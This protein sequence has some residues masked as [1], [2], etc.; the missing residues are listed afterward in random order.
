MFHFAYP[1]CGW[2][3]GRWRQG[4]VKSLSMKILIIYGLSMLSLGLMAETTPYKGKILKV[5][6]C[7]VQQ[8][9]DKAERLLSAIAKGDTQP[10]YPVFE[11]ASCYLSID[12]ASVSYSP[13]L[14]YRTLRKVESLGQRIEDAELFL[15]NYGL[16]MEELRNAIEVRLFTDAQTENSIAG[17]DRFLLNIDNES[18]KQ[19]A[20]ERRMLLA[21]QSI[22]Q[23]P[24]A[25]RCQAFID[26]YPQGRYTAEITLLRDRLI[27][28]S[29]GDN[30]RQLELFIQEHPSSPYA[31]EARAK[32]DQI[33]APELTI[34]Q[35]RSLAASFFHG[36]QV[37][38]VFP[39][40]DR[41]NG[42]EQFIAVVDDQILGGLTVAQCS[43]EQVLFS[44][45]LP[46]T[47]NT[48]LD[49]RRVDR[50]EK[51]VIN[52]RL[53]ILVVYRYYTY[54]HDCADCVERGYAV[55]DPV[56]HRVDQVVI[57][58]FDLFRADGTLDRIEG[59]WLPCESNERTVWL[60][61]YAHQELGEAFQE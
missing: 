3:L 60:K 33:Y 20:E 9:M 14:A 35:S 42:T 61:A 34:E 48:A 2:S 53:L 22:I 23:E 10:I 59:M 43:S 24:Y 26:R 6:D 36:G 47:D 51:V 52:K 21:Y 31:D 58:G 4:Y 38:E 50:V 11:L 30:L 54:S 16:S 1:W 8:E 55:Y 28:E 56:S 41:A 44:T 49:L 39:F 57:A 18:F 13:L 32:L 5:Y 15:S 7:I 25:D 40:A 46:K 19:A 17:W 37:I 29:I 45:V 27:Y 12:T